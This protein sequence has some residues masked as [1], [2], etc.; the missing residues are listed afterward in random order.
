MR[1]ERTIA[2]VTFDLTVWWT[3]WS[4]PISFSYWPPYDDDFSDFLDEAFGR[5]P[6][7]DAERC[8]II[9]IG[10]FDLSIRW[11]TLRP[12]FVRR[13]EKGQV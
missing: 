10:P 4:L 2:G 8:V 3:S 11:Q 9:G 7:A 12:S 13:L 6:F 1:I 5:R